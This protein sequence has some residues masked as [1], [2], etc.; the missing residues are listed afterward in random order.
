MLIQRAATDVPDE[1]VGVLGALQ[2]MPRGI[3]EVAIASL[4]HSWRAAL[5]CC[6]G[7]EPVS[8]RPEQPAHIVL[9][10]AGRRAI[11]ECAQRVSASED[12]GTL[13]RRLERAR[14]RHRAA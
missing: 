4:P 8:G 1:L 5:G 9:T 10:D 6:G 13:R 11:A 7:I 2:G 3:A 14:A 12:A